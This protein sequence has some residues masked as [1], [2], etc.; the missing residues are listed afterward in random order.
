MVKEV[1][2][3]NFSD[4]DVIRET[5]KRLKEMKKLLVEIRDLLKTA[6]GFE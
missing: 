2:Y 6:G 3:L 5:E 4:E 1:K